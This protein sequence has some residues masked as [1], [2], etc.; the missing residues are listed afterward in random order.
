M[1][2]LNIIGKSV[3]RKESLDKV[4]GAEKYTD[5]YEATGL[6]HARMVKNPYDH[7]RIKAIEYEN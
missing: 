4:T 3:P 5:D 1:Y 2:D 6:L 7:A